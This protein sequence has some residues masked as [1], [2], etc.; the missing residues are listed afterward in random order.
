VRCV[1]AADGGAV[2]Q[3]DLDG[4]C[5]FLFVRTLCVQEYVISCGSCVEDE[6]MGVYWWG[7]V[8]W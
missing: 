4:A 3:C 6:A 5:A 7:T 2:W 1:C 8:A